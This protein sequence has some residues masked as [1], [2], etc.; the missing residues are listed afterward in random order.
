MLSS[1][2]QDEEKLQADDDSATYTAL[3]SPSAANA[4]PQPHPH[5]VIL[6]PAAGVAAAADEQKDAAALPLM[7]STDDKGRALLA[8]TDNLF[9]SSHAVS[10]LQQQPSFPT[11]VSAP[12]PCPGQRCVGSWRFPSLLYFGWLTPLIRLGAR[13]PL[14]FPDLWQVFNA[15]RPG[16]VFALFAPAWEKQ[17]EKAAAA[18][19]PPKLLNTFVS[20]YGWLMLWCCLT[21]GY[22]NA[23]SLLG[24]QFL[25]E[26]VS[27]SV[28]ASQRSVP[29]WDGY[30]WCLLM[31]A[32]AVLAA[33]C[34]S[35]SLHLTTRLFIRMRNTLIIA[36]YRKSLRIPSRNRQDGAISNLMR[37]APQD[38]DRT[39]AGEQRGASRTAPD[40]A[41]AVRSVSALPLVS[42]LPLSLS[43]WL[44]SD[45]QKLVEFAQQ[46]QNLVS[47]LSSGGLCAVCCLLPTDCCCCCWPVLR[48]SVVCSHHHWR[49]CVRAVQASKSQRS[50]GALLSSVFTSFFVA[51]SHV[52]PL[53][54]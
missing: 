22:V 43:L 40:S 37:S 2:E 17:K 23:D 18:G 16:H 3:S 38:S 30:K 11:A 50:I 19:R 49:G 27:Y 36:I 32:S 47:L 33:F 12:L 14:Q 34:R 24:P 5:A 8:S 41:C 13:R 45:T 42:V 39:T 4:T 48:C 53:L 7:L 25:N 51:L 26:L 1:Y 9:S 46:C 54:Y 52:T 10:V 35:Y 28:T 29:A 21:Y 6:S 31:F 20:M 44:S 15:D